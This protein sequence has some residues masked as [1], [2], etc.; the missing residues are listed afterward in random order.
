METLCAQRAELRAEIV[1]LEQKLALNLAQWEA[2]PSV[3]VT[4]KQNLFP[5][6]VL[7]FP[8]A[9][10]I[11][12]HQVSRSRFFL[13]SSGRKVEVLDLG[14]EL[15]SH[16]NPSQLKPFVADAAAGADGGQAGQHFAKQGVLSKPSWC[17]A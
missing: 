3:M 1:G 17:A 6:V 10:F 15:P 8:Q 4:V 9:Q 14:A 16:V 7:N 2:E 5:R 12:E 11:A 13:D